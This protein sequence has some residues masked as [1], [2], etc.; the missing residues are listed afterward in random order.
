VVARLKMNDPSDSGILYDD[1]GPL[2]YRGLSGTKPEADPATVSAILENH[3]AKH[4]VVGHTVTGGV[5]WPR[6]DGRVVQIDT[7]IAAAYGGNM[8]YL[9]ITE[10]GLFGGYPEG[11][12][13]LPDDDEGRVAYLEQ[14]MALYPNNAR[15]IK[16]LESLTVVEDEAV[17]AESANVEDQAPGSGEAIAEGTESAVEKSVEIPICGISP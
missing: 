14:V 7:G 16:L 12:V 17:L 11:K 1:F 15:L 9:E 3:S 8:G 4:I 13:K 10:E 2:W 5:I 6:Y